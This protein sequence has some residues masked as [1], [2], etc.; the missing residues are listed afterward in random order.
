MRGVRYVYVLSSWIV[1]ILCSL[2]NHVIFQKY[3]F[4]IVYKN[5]LCLRH[6]CNIEKAFTRI[7]YLVFGFL[8]PNR[9]FNLPT[10]WKTQYST[11][12]VTLDVIYWC[13]RLLLYIYIYVGWCVHGSYANSKKSYSAG[14]DHCGPRIVWRLGKIY[15]TH[16]RTTNYVAVEFE[17][18]TMKS[19][20][21]HMDTRHKY[22][23]WQSANAASTDP[24]L[25]F[26][27]SRR[28]MAGWIESRGRI[29]HESLDGAC[30]KENR[31]EQS[32]VLQTGE[33]HEEK[34]SFGEKFVLRM[35]SV[36]RR[37]KHAFYRIFY[38]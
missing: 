5:W 37:R 12:M 17:A 24:C 15:T 34:L 22:T 30:P 27:R 35:N 11:V 13:P 20:S 9:W 1:F 6:I 23:S 25:C 4:K 19:A 38:N 14:W 2:L 28:G 8:I 26:V 10:A 31:Q 36:C 16:T 7:T 33:K 18:A 29:G 21:W 3:V 32:G